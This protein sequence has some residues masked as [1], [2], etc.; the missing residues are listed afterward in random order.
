MATYSTLAII[1]KALILC[2]A[3]TVSSIT[4]DTPNARALNAVYEIAR[5]D[6]LTENKWTF[7]TTRSTLSTVATTTFA[8]LHSEESY[9]YTKPSASLRI[10]EM[11]D[12]RAIWREEGDYILSNTADL[13]VKYSFDQSDLSKWAPSAISAFIDR[14]AADIC[15]MILN[16]A[17]KAADFMA[18]YE[19]ISLPK[20]MA[21][22]SQT[23]Y[24]QGVI[25]DYWANS[26]YGQ[27]SGD[28][29]RSY[30]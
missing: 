10:W 1:N 26:K 19:K 16:S 13:A 28:P 15:F 25:D 11:N 30:G 24:Q 7:S 12:E 21:E 22:N 3:N 9:A 20:A 5:K 14:L 27:N 29:S 6:F 2:G 23:G 4:D 8:W 18:K 17:T